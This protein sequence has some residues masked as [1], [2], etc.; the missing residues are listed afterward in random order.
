M[1]T[2]KQK[3]LLALA[4]VAVGLALFMFTCNG[5]PEAEA[6]T[7]PNW[8]GHNLDA[9]SGVG[10]VGKYPTGRKLSSVQLVDV[11]SVTIS[12]WGQGPDITGAIVW[13]DLIPDG[14]AV[15]DTALTITSGT[16]FFTFPKVKCEVIIISAGS[17]TVWGE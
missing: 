13:H 17:A 4:L 5:A 11:A 1:K 15:G 16:P 6:A 12:F 9:T 10:G 14:Y 3:A 2:N 7:V 8:V